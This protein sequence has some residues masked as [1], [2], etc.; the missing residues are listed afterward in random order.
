MCK[1]NSQERLYILWQF[2]WWIENYWISY[3]YANNINKVLVLYTNMGNTCHMKRRV[4]LRWFDNWNY[5]VSSNQQKYRVL[6]W[7]SGGGWWCGDANL[8]YFF[9]KLNW[10]RK[11]WQAFR[12][13]EARKCLYFSTISANFSQ[14]YV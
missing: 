10:N 12:K 5:C 3:T 13:I 2:E 11:K 7:C 8:S 4:N 9:F 14:K 6:S 1:A